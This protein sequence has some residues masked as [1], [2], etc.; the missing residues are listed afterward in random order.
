M[1]DRRQARRAASS[2]CR[3]GREA[4]PDL[5]FWMFENWMRQ[6]I[7]DVGVAGFACCRQ[8]Q[9]G[10]IESPSAKTFW[11]LPGSSPHPRQGRNRR[12]RSVGSLHRESPTLELEPSGRSERSARPLRHHERRQAGANLL[13]EGPR[14]APWIGAS[15]IARESC[16]GFPG[17]WL[18]PPPG[19]IKSGGRPKKGGDAK[20]CPAGQV[21]ENDEKPPPPGIINSGCNDFV[22]G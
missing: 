18:I 19:S 6:W 13:R 3:Q 8:H 4:E 16:S 20:T 1:R 12:S 11:S 7:D 15:S 2:L 5:R 17:G 22:A 9:F 21:F 10:R 14:P